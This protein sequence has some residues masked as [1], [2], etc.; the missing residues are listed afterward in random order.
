MKEKLD[1]LFKHETLYY[2]IKW[3]ILASIIG[4]VAGFVGFAFGMTIK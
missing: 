4:V 1:A 2:F 3:S